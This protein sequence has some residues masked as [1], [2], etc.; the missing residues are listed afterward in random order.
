M[1]DV[2]SAFTHLTERARAF[3]S[4]PVVHVLKECSVE[5]FEVVV[6]E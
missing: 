5:G 2:G 3:F 6:I 1:D 4:G